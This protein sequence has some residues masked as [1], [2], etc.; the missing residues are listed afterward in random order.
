MLFRSNKMAGGTDIYK[1]I[2]AVARE[3]PANATVDSVKP[4]R[5]WKA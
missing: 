5:W 1:E 2:Y 4:Q 3:I